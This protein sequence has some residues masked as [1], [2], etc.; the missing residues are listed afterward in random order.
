MAVHPSLLQQF[1]LMRLF[2][3]D[4]LASLAEHSSSRTFSKREVVLAKESPSPSLMFLLEGR[5]Q[6]LDFTMD[7]REVGLHFIEEGQYFG[8]ISV[9]DGLPSPEVVIATK[10]SQVV[11]VPAREIQVHIFASPLAIKAITSGLTQRI[12]NQANQRQILGI[13]SPL[14]R[15][16]ALLQNLSRDGKNP[17]LIANAPTHQEIAIMVNLT[18]ETVTRAFQVLQSQGALARDG[19]DLK[20]DIG[21]LKQLAEKSVD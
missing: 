18:R 15:I 4:A 7:G 16:C 9:L 11:M 21:K 13:I 2:Q 10:K 17:E 3:A 20:V 8:E 6:S 5:L 12:R 19:D 1:S 14:Q